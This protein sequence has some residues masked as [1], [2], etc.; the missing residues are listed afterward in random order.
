MKV[1]SNRKI[2]LAILL[3]G[4][5]LTAGFLAIKTFIGDV[6]PVILPPSKDLTEIIEKQEVGDPVDFPLKIASG[7][8]IGVFAK[9]LGNARDLQ[10]SPG[11]T[12]LVSSKKSG[13]IYALPDTDNDGK[14]D[15]KIQVLTDLDK[16]HGL[17]FHPFD[18]SQGKQV[19]LF[20]AELR[21]VTRYSWDE[22]NMSAKFEKKILDL[23]YNGGHSTRSIVINKDGQLFVTI[24]SSW[25]LF[26][27]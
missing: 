26:Q 2:W 1:I 10:F 19:K 11:G 3:I 8:K 5:I 13:K 14:A 17:A 22:E 9:D 18:T 16:P 12:L 15:K 25:L 24:G 4:A 27:I 6:R 20:V 23:P 21:K 7:F